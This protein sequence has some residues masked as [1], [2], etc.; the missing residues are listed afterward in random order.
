MHREPDPMD[1]L[2][3]GASIVSGG[4]AGA[5]V[6]AVT[7]RIFYWRT[8]RTQF[9]PVLNDICAAYAIRMQRADGRYLITTVGMTPLPEDVEFVEHRVSFIIRLISFNELREARRLRKDLI[10]RMNPEGAPQGTV[11][12][13]D[14]MPDY[15][16]IEKCLITVQK[17]L[18]LN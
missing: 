17:K 11:L 18:K 4:L 2:Q 9:H 13:T 3:L 5:S 10:I 15:Q 6:G 1:P 8:L 16:A 12:K 14:L 7:N